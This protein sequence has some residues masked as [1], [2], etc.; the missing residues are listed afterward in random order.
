[1]AD[2]AVTDEQ[3]R[4]FLDRNPMVLR[5]FLRKESRL[6]T[7]WWVDTLRRHVRHE[8]ADAAAFNRRA[9]L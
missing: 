5:E 7:D 8:T 4:A 2:V 3:I 6:R 9:V 1:V